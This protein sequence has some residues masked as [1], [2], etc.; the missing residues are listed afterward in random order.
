MIYK[1]ASN[2]TTAGNKNSSVRRRGSTG[3]KESGTVRVSHLHAD[4]AVVH[5]GEDNPLE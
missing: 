5:A 1:E 3:A 2:Q 4:H